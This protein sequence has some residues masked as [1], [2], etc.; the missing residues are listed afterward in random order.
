MSERLGRIISNAF[1]VQVS[2]DKFP[3]TRVNMIVEQIPLINCQA[4]Y[5]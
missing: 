5:D 4:Y 3:D 2:V 1:T